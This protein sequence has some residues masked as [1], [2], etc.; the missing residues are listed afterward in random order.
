[1]KKEK[2]KTS[3]VGGEMT[4][5]MTPKVGYKGRNKIN[6]VYNYCGDGGHWVSRMQKMKS[7]FEK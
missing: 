4:L 2:T 1:M 6:N 7:W 5:T 3:Q